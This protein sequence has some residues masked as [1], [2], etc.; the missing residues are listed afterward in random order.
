MWN[1]IICDRINRPCE[2]CCAMPCRVSAWMALCAQHRTSASGTKAAKQ[3]NRSLLA[4]RSTPNSIFI[5]NFSRTS[6]I[7]RK[8]MYAVLCLEC[9]R[10]VRVRHWNSLP[11]PRACHYYYFIRA[12]NFIFILSNARRTRCAQ[13]EHCWRCDGVHA[14]NENPCIADKM[15]VCSVIR[16]QKAI[17]IESMWSIAM[18]PTTTTHSFG[19]GRKRERPAEELR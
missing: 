3:P 13:T 2:Y 7:N 5:W 4:H 11:L 8:K 10:W 16:V 1:G 6:H 18:A 14:F 12:Q 17:L 19:G 9:G 15:N